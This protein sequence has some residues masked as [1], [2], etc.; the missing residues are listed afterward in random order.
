MEFFT[1]DTLKNIPRLQ[2]VAAY[3]KRFC[4]EQL[5]E[6]ISKSN[7]RKV[8][9]IYGLR[10][11][12]KTVLM[13]QLLNEIGDSEKTCFIR[14]EKG[15]G[16]Q[17]LKNVLN[18]NLKCDYFF[19]DEVT[20]L[21]DFIECSSILAD[22]YSELYAKK[23]IMAGTDSLGFYLAKKDE[24]YDRTYMIHT[25]YIPYKEYNYLLGKGLED[26]IMYGGTLTD[27]SEFYN[28][29]N[30]DEYTNTAIARNIQHS[31]DNLGRDGEYGALA[32]FREKGEM[33]TFI[34]KIVELYTRRF[35][36]EIVNKKFKTHDF[37]NL[38][39]YAVRHDIVEDVAPLDTRKNEALRQEI[40][41]ELEIRE[42]LLN[43]ATEKAV[44]EAKKYLEM[45]DVV[46][47][48]PNTDEVIFT[49][50]GLKYCQAAAQV[51]VLKST[52]LL[53]YSVTEREEL[54]KVL[55]NDIKGRILE[56]IIF[57]QLSKD[58][59]FNK[60]Y[61]LDKFKTAAADGEFDI[62]CI[63]RR[64]NEAVVMEVKHSA[65]RVEKQT[66][67]LNNAQC[68]QE[69]EAWAHTK[70]AGKMVV[71]MGETVDEKCFNVNY[72]GAEDL[73]KSPL[74]YVE[75]AKENNI[76]I[77]ITPGELAEEIAK[78]PNSLV[79]TDNVKNLGQRIVASHSQGK[80]K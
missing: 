18:D 13:L 12:G 39:K 3:K 73:L 52:S 41:S 57:Y 49:Q 54:S 21:E 6:Y 16:I 65:K 22:K 77:S 38:K 32:S 9:S 59:D 50:P 60:D 10:R 43:Q 76:I 5:K 55:L 14:C 48:V 42:P 61:V 8:M 71:Y 40:M 44:S 29:D 70:I 47:L 67:H 79:V 51:E 64:S 35:T 31:L 27:G 53:P 37:L 78:F 72:V 23:I 15:D 66:R 7:T 28:K 2:E 30:C 34:N 75:R 68:C 17:D 58:A 1:G 25:T 11:T 26:Y 4:F 63:H 62:V 20:K 74:K 69:F 36:M 80:T 56:D 45:L 24:L 46:L 33:T 19:V